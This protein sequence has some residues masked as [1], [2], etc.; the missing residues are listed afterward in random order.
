M[1]KADATRMRQK[2]APDDIDHAVSAIQLSAH[3]LFKKICLL[4]VVESIASQDFL[5]KL[6]AVRVAQAFGVADFLI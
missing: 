2:L 6:R 4:G 3:R 5:H 1:P